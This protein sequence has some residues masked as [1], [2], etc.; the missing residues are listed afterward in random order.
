MNAAEQIRILIVEDHPVFRFGLRTL[1]N[2]QPGMEVVG[3]AM[4][5]EEGVQQ[6]IELQPD[7]VLMDLNLPG[8]NGIEA[9]R[10]IL[11]TDPRIAILVLTM[12]DN[13][14]VFEI[15]RVGGRGYLLKG[16]DPDETVRAI[17]VVANGEAIFSP[18]V[19][20]RLIDYFAQGDHRISVPSF[21]DLTEREVEILGLIAQGYTNTRIAERLVLSPKTVRNHVS[22]IYS[23]LQVANRSQAISRA[24]DAGLEKG[25]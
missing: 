12:L 6:A 4:S 22:N 16:A 9:T 20:Q 5:G 3:E 7:V 10:Q 11:E 8:L 25:E 23:K 24:R 19:A 21:P 1:L 18:Q 13:D 15:M 17:R 2:A 14:S